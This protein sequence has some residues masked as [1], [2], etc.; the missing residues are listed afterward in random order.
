MWPWRR[1]ASSAHDARAERRVDDRAFLLGLDELYREVIKRHEA[2]AL[3]DSARTVAAQLRLERD[4]EVPLEGYYGESPLLTEYIQWM[5]SLQSTP[6]ERISEVADLPQYQRLLALASSPHLGRPVDVG[7]LLPRARDALSAALLATRPN[8]TIP[9]V[10]NAAK[11]SAH[12]TEDVSLVGLAA[13]A[14]DEVAVA[15]LRET[16]V[17]YAEVIVTGIPQPVKNEFVWAVSPELAAR[18][19]RFVEIAN[20]LLGE[21][22]PAPIAA[23]AEEYWYAF[24]RNKVVGR[25]VRIASDERQV[26]HR[27]Y[28]WAIKEDEVRL[29]VEEFWDARVW[30]T[31]MYRQA[32]RDR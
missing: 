19:A 17:L 32:Q 31:E 25:C 7:K 5:R 18:A 3:L 9:V 10:M 4:H 15:A 13:F 14:G 28:H 16:V 11:L 6:A 30:T 1:R 2:G 22:L 29:A 20:T 23:S 26:P 21:N 24:S 8:W 12:E 27:H